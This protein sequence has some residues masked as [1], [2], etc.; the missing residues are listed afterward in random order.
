VAKP[1]A[2]RAAEI[3]GEI[4]TIRG[5]LDRLVSE[6]DQRRRNWSP[7]RVARRHPSLSLMVGGVAVAGIA[8]TWW[9]VRR[10]R[11]RE[12]RSWLARGRHLGEAL[13]Q[14]MSGKLTPAP[15][16]IG[17]KVAAAAGT[18][19]AAVAGRRLARRLF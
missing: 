11:A 3:E 13:R 5:N 15:P 16:S 2:R 19:A 6:L 9:L 1:E 18:A 7:V 12:Q 8:T 14:L 4:K 10:A 17:W